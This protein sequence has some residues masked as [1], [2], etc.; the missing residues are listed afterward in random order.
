MERLE[1]LETFESYSGIQAGIYEYD[2]KKDDALYIYGSKP[3]EVSTGWN[4]SKRGKYMK[5]DLHFDKTEGFIEA[6]KKIGTN[7]SQVET[8][9]NGLF[10][11]NFIYL[12]NLDEISVRF[13]EIGTSGLPRYFHSN[14]AEN[15]LKKRLAQVEHECSILKKIFEE[16]PA[17][18]G[19]VQALSE[20]EGGPYVNTVHTFANP[21]S[22]KAFGV[23][24]GN[25]SDCKSLNKSW[26]NHFK[27][28][29]EYVYLS[30]SYLK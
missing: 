28:A 4:G 22:Q 6:S 24:I 9:E 5:K 2:E 10:F 8:I 3:F 15:R 21:A 25:A 26:S 20:V 19:V 16:S 14:N 17:F 12:N 1:E 7:T 11:L 23:Q 30:F 18:M 27:E 13:L 29:R